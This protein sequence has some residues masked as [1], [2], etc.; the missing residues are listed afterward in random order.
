MT[1]LLAQYAQPTMPPGAAAA[2]AGLFGVFFLFGLVFTVL[3]IVAYYFIAQRAG[4]NPWLSLLALIPG[5]NFI[6]ILI[7]AFSEWPIQRE[8]RVLKA[9]LGGGGTPGVATYGDAASG[10]APGRG[11]IQPL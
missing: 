5:V 3:I 11:P 7:F 10:Y 9:Q 8:V 4:Y 6:L 2:V 1:T